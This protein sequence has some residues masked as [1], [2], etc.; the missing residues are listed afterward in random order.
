VT[1]TTIQTGGYT[2]ASSL[3]LA[4]YVRYAS[5]GTGR[6]TVSV[7]SGAAVEATLADPNAS[8]TSWTAVAALS[9]N[10]AHTITVTPIRSTTGTAATLTVTRDT[11][12]P[13]LTVTE[14]TSGDY[15]T[16][17]ITFAGTASDAS[18]GL[19]GV[20]VSLDGGYSWR[21]A[22]VNAGAF[23]LD[24][25]VEGAQ[26]FAS[27]PARVRAR[28]NAG[29]ANTA[30]VPVTVDNTPPTGLQPV[31]FSTPEGTYLA[32]DSVLGV[33]WNAVSDA[34]GTAEV[35]VN[36]DQVTN[37]LPSTVRSGTHLDQGLNA[38]G[39]WYVHIA[40]RDAAGNITISHYG[41]WYVR[42]ATGAFALQ[43]QEILVDGFIDLDHGEWSAATQQLDDDERSGRSYTLYTVWDGTSF[44]LGWQGAYW[45][46]DGELQSYM[47]LGGTAG[48]LDP[49]HPLD[50]GKLPTTANVCIEITGITSGTLWTY[51]TTWTAQPLTFAVGPSGDTEVKVPWA[52]MPGGAALASAG[53]RLSE[54]TGLTLLALAVEPD[55]STSSAFPTTN[56]TSGALTGAYGWSSVSST[57]DPNVGIAQPVNVTLDATSPQVGSA[58]WGP[59]SE[60]EYDISIANNETSAV[61]GLTLALNATPGLMLWTYTGATCAAAPCLQ[62]ASSWSLAV[63]S[64][65]AGATAHITVTGKLQHILA[66]YESVTNT[67]TLTTPVGLV[68]QPVEQQVAHHVDGKVPSVVFVSPVGTVGPITQTVKGLASDGSGVGIA[69]VELSVNNGPW[70][71]ATGTVAWSSLAAPATGATTLLLEARAT[72]V[73]GLQSP[74]VPLLLAVDS[75]VPTVTLQLDSVL[76]GNY[77]VLDGATRDPLPVG[78]LVTAVDVQLD[79]TEA[80]WQPATISQIPTGIT[81]DWSWVWALPAEDNVPHTVRVRASDLVGNLGYSSWLPCKVDSIAPVVTT[82]HVVTQV[83]ATGEGDMALA[84][85]TSVLSGSVTDGSGLESIWVRIY[86]DWGNVYTE[87]VTLVGDLWDYQFQTEGAASGLYRLRVEAIDNAGN[88]VLYGPYEL[89]VEEQP[90]AGLQAESN[91]PKAVNASV[92]LTATLTAG[93]N[94]TYTWAFGDGANGSGR[95]TTHSYA[96]AGTYTATVVARNS[97]SQLTDTVAVLI[98]T[99]VGG[100]SADNDGPTVLG[101][102]TGL[103]ASVTAGTSVQYDWAFGDGASGSGEAPSHTYAAF[104]SYVAVV[105]AHN[106]V[107]SMTATTTVD[108]DVPVAGVQA[109]NDSP[110]MFGAQTGLGAS[111]TAGSRVSYTWAFGDGASGVGQSLK[112]VYLGTG[113][114]T[115]V[116]TAS[117]SVSSQSAQTAVQ[118]ICPADMLRIEPTWLVHCA[119]WNHGFK[120]SYVNDAQL[121][122]A[123][124][125]LAISVPARSMV[126][127]DM[128]SPGLQTG[129][130]NTVY[131]NLGTVPGSTT[132]TRLLMLHFY[133]SI[134]NGTHVQVNAVATTGACPPMTASVDVEIRT[135]GICQTPQPTFTPTLTPSVTPTVTPTVT[136]TP[137]STA[138]PTLTPG[139]GRVYLPLLR[140]E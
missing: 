64:V 33:T 35:L 120:L 92:S 80:A 84:A 27:Y 117:N 96:A 54:V 89:E 6:V 108:V 100:A 5:T 72:D 102:P 19:A 53:R 40:A 110:T 9:T 21:A 32:I 82:T 135:D 127:F 60:I 14:P 41:P 67:L 73:Y 99:P 115:A 85:M 103:S 112:H 22:T 75:T 113:A 83:Y 129:P 59:D 109:V 29:N 81:Q 37:T 122:I 71:D 134:P 7:D 16:R 106:S 3:A 131:W 30:S 48:T 51:S 52:S 4:G 126:M 70:H 57:T 94:V 86:D 105:T 25:T 47:A 45:G 137:T 34:S 123:G 50:Q 26:D 128:S 74:E 91:A 65:A 130:N 12:Q 78:S 68:G 140:R 39:K 17:T 28:D 1:V 119:S 23:S 76:G 125:T 49:V 63:P 42:R 11:T 77:A 15:V 136:R 79:S 121:P 24:W 61:S 138:T 69:K 118:I 114:F 104:G 20:D 95:T 36:I 98:E 62:G 111:V 43:S 97:V 55:G 38:L 44:Y 87:P 132:V 56:G 133:S 2:N 46:I 124:V 8:S 10:G 107:S 88:G 66:L 90:I 31:T 13:S 18:A 93:S 101:N 116:V 58:A 139:A